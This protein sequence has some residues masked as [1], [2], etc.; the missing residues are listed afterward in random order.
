MRTDPR[1]KA[2]VIGLITKRTVSDEELFAAK[3][4]KTQGAVRKRFSEKFPADKCSNCGLTDWLGQ[5][6]SFDMDHINGDNQDNRL[7]NLRWL[8]P[9]CHRQTPT[10]GSR[11]GLPMLRREHKCLGCKK[12]IARSSIRCRPCNLEFIRTKK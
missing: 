2:E 8:C 5:P 9:N 7:E 12:D 3:S 1:R 6:I 4:V 11:R 10:F